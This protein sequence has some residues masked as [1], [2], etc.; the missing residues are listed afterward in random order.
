MTE[1]YNTLEG[2]LEQICE[3]QLEEQDLAQRALELA[4]EHDPK[5]LNELPRLYR[6]EIKRILNEE[7]ETERAATIQD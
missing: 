6:L 4:Q 2:V 3:T 5:E 1:Q 7:G